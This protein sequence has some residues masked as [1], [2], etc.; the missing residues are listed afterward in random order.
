MF[1]QRTQILSQRTAF[2]L[3][4]GLVTLV[5]VGGSL[6]LV[7]WIFSQLR[8][9]A[10][11]EAPPPSGASTAYVNYDPNAPGVA[12][13]IRP[14][15]LQAMTAY[16][17]QYPE[18]QNI[19]VL[20]GWNTAQIAGYMVSQVS[21]GLRVDC[22]YCHNLA[23]GNFA[24]ESNPNKNVARQ[25]MLMSADLNQ[26]WITLL[27][28]SVG[29][30]QVTCATCHNGRA[31]PVTYP[32]DQSPLPDDYR[33][34]LDNLDAL[35]VTGA[36]DPELNE[37]QINQWTMSHMNNSLGV[38]CNFCHNANYFPSNEIANKGY[39][40]TMLNMV[41]HIQ[42][43]YGPRGN[44]LLKNNLIP[45]CYTCHQNNPIPPGAAQAGQVPP[46]LSSNPPA[47]LRQ[48]SQCDGCHTKTSAAPGVVSGD[49]AAD[50]KRSD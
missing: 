41:K 12:Q 40:L 32:A 29:Q 33:L 10:R 8:S 17:A 50:A 47:G 21:G 48:D 30:Y 44:N 31:I 28:A 49:A 6:G 24:D 46:P 36:E 25:M 37:V 39:A 20:Q 23:N 13:Y 34:P 7:S 27:P 45:S 16:T 26:N 22:A 1:R 4:F 15:S 14:E 3:V 43:T 2:L 35:R 38:G 11:A 18:P 9:V 42:D 5:L 19:Q